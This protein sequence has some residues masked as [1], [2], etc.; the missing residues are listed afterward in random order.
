MLHGASPDRIA[1][2]TASYL[3]ADFRW[4]HDGVWRRLVIG[5]AMIIADIER[6]D[7]AVAPTL[8]PTQNDNPVLSPARN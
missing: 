2:L 1:Q 7:R 5:A 8:V 6:L 4:E 3:T